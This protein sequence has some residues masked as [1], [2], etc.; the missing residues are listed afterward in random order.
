[1]FTEELDWEKDNY[2][3]RRKDWPDNA[4]TEPSAIADK[5]KTKTGFFRQHKR[6]LIIAGA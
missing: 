1:M 3:S 2:G 5:S 4:H 6:K